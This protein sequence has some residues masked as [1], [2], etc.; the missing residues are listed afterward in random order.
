M[1]RFLAVAI[2]LLLTVPT[3]AAADPGR[4][5]VYGGSV[6]T[7]ADA[8]WQVYVRT[9]D[10]YACGGSIVDP[11]HVV[12]AAHCADADGTTP[13]APASSFT[14]LAG[15][16]DVSTY[17]PGKAPPAGT[18][19]A[20]VA[21]YR[22]H[23]YYDNK[24]KSDDAMVFTLS[25]PL[26]L[27]GSPN[28]KAIAMA[29]VGSEVANGTGVRLTGFGQSSS[30]APDGKLRAL[31][32]TALDDDSCRLPPQISSMLICA[33]IGG[34]QSPCHGDSGGP[35]TLADGPPVLVGIVSFGSTAGCGA[36]PSGFT[37]VAAP[38]VRQFLDGNDAPPKA[39]RPSAVSVLR[40]VPVQGSP[41]SCE[42]GTWDGSPAFTY[43]FQADGVGVLQSGQSP[44][45]VPGRAD[46]GRAI[47]C[48][49]R[50]TNAGGTSTSR[51]GTAPGIGPDTV[52][53]I[54]RLQRWSCRGRTCRFSLAATD[55]NSQGA[56]KVT[57]IAR[58][59]GRD[60]NLKVKFT[61]PGRYAVTTT[62]LPRRV[63]IRFTFT[64]TDAAGNR[65]TL[66]PRPTVRLGG[67]RR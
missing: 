13:P 6:I 23:P 57:G 47:T 2:G 34:G 1:P 37:D 46:L 31:V 39:P 21:S 11:T 16:S 27:T 22:I 19:V 29:P 42:P 50:A 60:H 49:V 41:L 40:G 61:A 9:A 63:K 53:P 20:S 17:Q 45:Y 32:L 58:Y 54:G 67:A 65:R 10:G 38:E 35:L 3:L 52:K 62:R 24:S 26:D 28:V 36:G 43:I 48:V 5:R 55:P 64:V 51:T 44:V 7:A 4:P 15:F 14:V 18:Q 59:R 30:G 56:L 33:D 12:S 25:A 8:P 66:S